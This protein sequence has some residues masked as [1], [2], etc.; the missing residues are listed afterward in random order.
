MYYFDNSATTLVK[1]PQVA[2]AVYHAIQGQTIGN[3]S[4]GSHGPALQA[5]RLVEQT[6][7]KIARLFNAQDASQIICTE[8]AISIGENRYATRFSCIRSCGARSI[9]PIGKFFKRKY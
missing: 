2:E 4:R 9:G 7:M 1:P 5:L 3:P 8:T 6:R